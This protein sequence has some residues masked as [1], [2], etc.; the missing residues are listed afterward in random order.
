MFDEAAIDFANHI[1]RDINLA[2]L[3]QNILPFKFR[4]DLILHKSANHQV[5][6][7]LLR[8]H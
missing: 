7:V 5:D 1:W 8:N 6:Q 3:E 2:N 4:A